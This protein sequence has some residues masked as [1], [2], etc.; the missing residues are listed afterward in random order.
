M[1]GRR[2]IAASASNSVDDAVAQIPNGA[3]KWFPWVVGLVSLAI[4]VLGSAVFVY[5]MNIKWL[6][7]ILALHAVPLVSALLPIQLLRLY[8]AW[9]GVFL[10][11]QYLLL[12]L[13]LGENRHFETLPPNMERTIDLAEGVLPGIQ[14]PQKITTDAKGFRANPSVDYAEKRG[15]R[16]FAIGASTTEQIYLG[17]DSTWTYL[18][19]EMLAARIGGPVEVINTGLSGTRASQHLKVL[20]HI[21]EYEP[22]CV[23]M[24]FGVNDW[25][26][27]I[28]E[29]FARY[30]Y[31]LAEVSFRDSLLG[32]ALRIALNY[33]SEAVG[34]GIQ[35]VKAGAPHGAQIG[36]LSLPDRRTFIADQ[37]TADYRATVDDIGNV[38]R[39]ADVPC[40]F[41]TQPHGYSPTADPAYHRYFWMTP[42]DE[43]YT[44]DLTSMEAIANLYNSY[45][46]QF[47]NEQGFDLIDL[48]AAMPAGTQFFYDD[49]H[50]NTEGARRVANVILGELE[51]T[52]CSFRN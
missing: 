28:R 46:V 9:F 23:I 51:S 7:V 15:T 47:A 11:L 36:S 20:H 32:R 27:H 18:L 39:V 48:A 40:I 49:V 6:A 21:L 45:L 13:S 24:L 50:F 10:I 30:R 14:G 34:D 33:G 35:Q 43:D 2:I 4:G 19:Q 12:L 22:D 3:L 17:D 16:I 41:L 31:K 29:H 26:K 8:G 37:V 5:G 44:L 52:A 38:C 25:N 1:Y 42:F